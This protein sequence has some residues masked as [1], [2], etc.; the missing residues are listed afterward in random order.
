M[1]HAIENAVIGAGVIGLAVARALALGGREVVVLEAAD[2]IGTGISSRNSEVIHAGIYYPQASLKARL[3]VAG[4]QALYRYCESRGVACE[5]VGKLIVATDESEVGA[6][7]ELRQK[8]AGNGVDDLE[9]MSAAAARALEPALA[10]AGALLSPSTGIVDSHGLMLAYQGD[11]EARGAVIALRSRLL[12]G[13]VAGG[14]FELEAGAEAAAT[15]L[16]CEVLVNAAGLGAQALARALDGMPPDLVPARHLAKGSYFSLSGKAPFRHL[17]YP[18]PGQASLGLHYSLDLAGRAKFGPDIEW[19]DDIDYDVDPERAEA[20]YAAIR[21]YYPGLEPGALAPD[22][23]GIRPKLQAPGEPAADFLIQG[24]A[25]H[26]VAGLVNLF[27]IESPGL[28]A[29]PAIADHV[30]GLLQG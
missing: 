26:G 1:L 27:G 6:L 14:G 11:A 19:I 10:C 8:G 30:V 20:F 9:L 28:T 3:C 16:S 22:Y 29:A 7:D 2:A 17:I 12:G 25:D 21:R 4:K 15:R 13:R 18:V 5:R 24:P 23:A